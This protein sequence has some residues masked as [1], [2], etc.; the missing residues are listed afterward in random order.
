VACKK[1]LSHIV[2]KSRLELTLSTVIRLDF[3]DFF[4]SLDFLL[5][6]PT[7]YPPLDISRTTCDTAAEGPYRCLTL[8][9]E[10]KKLK[11]LVEMVSYVLIEVRQNTRQHKTAYHP[12]YVMCT[13]TTATDLTNNEGPLFRV[14]ATKAEAEEATAR[15]TMA[16]PHLMV[17]CFVS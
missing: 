6:S 9:F 1:R 17:L 5:F 8:Q 11:P 7:M 3:L 2:F 16:E 4:C 13:A 10:R 14:G 15:A 12:R